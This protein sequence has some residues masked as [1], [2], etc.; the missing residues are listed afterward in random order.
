MLR[1]REAYNRQ[2]LRRRQHP[3]V[4]ASEPVT[5]TGTVAITDLSGR[6]ELSPPRADDEGN[7]IQKERRLLLHENW[8]IYFH[9]TNTAINLQINV[10]TNAN[11]DLGWDGVTWGDTRESV[12]S[13]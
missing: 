12:D 7:I 9:Q 4:V 2:S 11:T 10:K 5:A 13:G 8:K 6:C 1:V 3:L